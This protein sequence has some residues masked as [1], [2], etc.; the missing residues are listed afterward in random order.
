MLA[1][2]EARHDCLHRTLATQ[3]HVNLSIRGNG[4]EVAARGANTCTISLKGL[5]D[6]DDRF[7]LPEVNPA[8][9]RCEITFKMAAEFLIVVGLILTDK[10]VNTSI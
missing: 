5:D 3:E 8:H 4:R 10:L 1:R 9:S 6:A 2:G 7:V